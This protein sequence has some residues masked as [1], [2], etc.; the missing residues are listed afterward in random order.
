MPR[1]VKAPPV[2]SC[3]PTGGVTGEVS[4]VVQPA[5]IAPE[6][7]TSR[8]ARR[9]LWLSM[10]PGH[11]SDEPGSRGEGPPKGRWRRGY[12]LLPPLVVARRLL[13]HV[14]VPRGP[15]GLGHQ[16]AGEDGEAPDAVLA[17]A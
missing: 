5:R 8:G 1:M 2:K 13:H 6:S 4:G 17:T 11:A 10:P 12:S 15:L 3:L 14:R 9:D 7:A 16:I